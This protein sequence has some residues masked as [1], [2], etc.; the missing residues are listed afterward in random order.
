MSPDGQ[1]QLWDEGI[2]WYQMQWCQGC[3]RHMEV[4]QRGGEG[5]KVE[6]E[7]EQDPLAVKESQDEMDRFYKRMEMIESE[8][9]IGSVEIDD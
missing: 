7:G 3:D 2:S 8:E 9:P 4:K 1:E 5:L 6:T